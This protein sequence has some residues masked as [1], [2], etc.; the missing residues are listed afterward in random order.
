MQKRTKNTYKFSFIY[1]KRKEKYVLNVEIFKYLE[2]Y[3]NSVYSGYKI[4][5]SYNM[6]NKTRLLT[7]SGSIA[8]V[9]QGTE[10]LGFIFN[11]TFR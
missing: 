5:D 10:Y 3:I 8:D 9:L 4:I 2:E 7:I 6:D 1:C 11:V